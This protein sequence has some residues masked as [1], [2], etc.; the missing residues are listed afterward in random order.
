M[1]SH[2]WA[3]EPSKSNT[4]IGR[5]AGTTSPIALADLRTTT[6]HVSSGSYRSTGSSSEIWLWS[7]SIVTAAV[8][9][10]LVMEASREPGHRGAADGHRAD[11]RDLAVVAASDQARRARNRSDFNVY[12]QDVAQVSYRCAF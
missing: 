11:D 8:V 10:G 2:T 4:V 12:P 9:M 1:R 7:I 5:A 3:S 6:G